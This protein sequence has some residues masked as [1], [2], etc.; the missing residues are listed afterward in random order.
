MMISKR[1][2][3]SKSSTATACGLV[4]PTPVFWAMNRPD[5]AVTSVKRSLGVGCLEAAGGRKIPKGRMAKRKQQYLIV[6]ILRSSWSFLLVQPHQRLCVAVE[7]HAIAALV[8]PDEV[9]YLDL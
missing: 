4:P 3:P 8:G 2:S 1:P 5:A 7:H 9:Q 6:E